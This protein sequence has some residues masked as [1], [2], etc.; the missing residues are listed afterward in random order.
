M[1][2][3]IKFELC[4]LVSCLNNSSVNTH[5]FVFRINFVTRTCDIGV[6]RYSKLKNSSGV[7]IP[8]SCLSPAFVNGDYTCCGDPIPGVLGDQV[9]LAI[10]VA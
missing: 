7:Y 6:R 5:L 8:L 1:E 3:G 10:V 4:K 2:I 9:H